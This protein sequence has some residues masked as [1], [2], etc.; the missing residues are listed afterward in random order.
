[1]RSTLNTLLF[2]LSLA[3][4]Q[5]SPAIPVPTLNL[6]ELTAQSDLILTGYVLSV[7]PSDLVTRVVEGN[8]VTGRLNTAEIKVDRK[9]KGLQAANLLRVIYFSSDSITGFGGVSAYSYRLFFL[10][11]VQNQVSFTSDY[12]PSIVAVPGNSPLET[13][14][15]NAVAGTLLAVLNS[16]KSPSIKIGAI[17]GLETIKTPTATAA[18]AVALQQQDPTI[19][20]SA[21]A[22][23]FER[24]NLDGLSIATKTLSHSEGTPS[25]LV[26]N[27]NYS[28][29]QGISD[30]IAIPFAIALLRNSS[31]ETRRSASSALMHIGTRSSIP[32]ILIALDDP[33]LEVQLYA[34][35]ALSNITGQQEWHPNLETFKSSSNAISSTL[36]R[37][38]K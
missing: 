13:D 1:M 28:I 19:Q 25:Y 6:P 7:T 10:K 22:A 2:F 14:A 34:V 35:L 12:Y 24:N 26:H 18:L 30:E 31:V 20:I 9:I 3:A 23:L 33:D 37:V 8:Q 4:A 16:D 38:G 11:M 27:L 15:L 32:G 36:A 5:Q 17:N 29:G 21:A